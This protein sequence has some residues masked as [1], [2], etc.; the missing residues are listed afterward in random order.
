L[1]LK[2]LLSRCVRG[3]PEPRI[4]CGPWLELL[5]HVPSP[6]VIH[7]LKLGVFLIRVPAFFDRVLFRIQFYFTLNPIRQVN[8]GSVGNV[9]DSSYHGHKFLGNLL[10][11]SLGLQVSQDFNVSLQSVSEMRVHHLRNAVESVLRGRLTDGCGGKAVETP[12]ALNVVLLF[13][14]GV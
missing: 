4:D 14:F 11:S 12:A 6:S 8:P 2:L 5:G 13:L 7:R 9:P 10:S 3:I 1:Y